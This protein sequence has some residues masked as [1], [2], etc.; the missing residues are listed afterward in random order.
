M[1][2]GPLFARPART[3]ETP[4][5][6]LPVRAALVL[7]NSETLLDLLQPPN[8]IR[9]LV[10]GHRFLTLLVGVGT[11]GDGLNCPRHASVG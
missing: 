2:Y 10:R 7:Q 6:R 9:K 5:V 11:G 8:D 3:V 4:D 1:L